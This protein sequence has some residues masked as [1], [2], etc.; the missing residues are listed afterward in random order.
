MAPQTVRVL[1]YGSR[2][3]LRLAGMTVGSVASVSDRPG[4]T[5]LWQ[6]LD[7]RTQGEAD[8]TIDTAG[9]RRF[10]DA[11]EVWLRKRLAEE[12]RD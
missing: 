7:R 3:A 8:A 1:R 12:R 2:L 4:F 5:D 6:R 10:A 11:A 9:C